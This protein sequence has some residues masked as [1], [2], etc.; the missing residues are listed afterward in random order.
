MR[1]NDLQRK[2][3]D[4]KL[5]GKMIDHGIHGM[6]LFELFFVKKDFRS[7][8]I[9]LNHL[10]KGGLFSANFFLWVAE[11]GGKYASSS[12]VDGSKSHLPQSSCGSRVPSRFSCGAVL[13]WPGTV[14]SGAQILRVQEERGESKH[15]GSMLEQFL[16]FSF[17]FPAHQASSSASFRSFRSEAK[18]WARW[19]G[20]TAKDGHGRLIAV[21]R[22]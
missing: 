19:Q 7:K 18:K 16:N 21:D 6:S 9:V 1:K 4:Q 20:C 3:L 11:D 14:G 2:A 22:A 17:C 12:R 10:A 13:G 15:L 8:K 5:G